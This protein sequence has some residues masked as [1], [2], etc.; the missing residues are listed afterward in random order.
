MLAPCGAIASVEIVTVASFVSLNSSTYSVLGFISGCQV[1]A[2]LPLHPHAPKPHASTWRY[3]N[4]IW[5]RAA[6]SL[7]PWHQIETLL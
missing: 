6:A 7:G 2:P 3:L 5:Y 1:L 4:L